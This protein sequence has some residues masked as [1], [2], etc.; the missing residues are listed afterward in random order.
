MTTTALPA[1]DVDLWG[2]EVMPDPYPIYRQL[3][4]TAA[5][6]FLELLR[7]PYDTVMRVCVVPVAY[8]TGETFE[9]ARRRPRDEVVLIDTFGTSSMQETGW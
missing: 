9:K 6:V 7:I 3:R 4:D 2:A 8:Y 5:A 1:S